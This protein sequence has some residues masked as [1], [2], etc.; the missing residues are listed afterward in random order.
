MPGIR[1]HPNYHGYRLD[2]PRFARLLDLAARRQVIVQF[3]A[4]LDDARHKWLTPSSPVD[5]QPLVQVITR[6]PSLRLVIAGGVAKIDDEAIRQ[7][8]SSNQAY[9]DFAHLAAT[10]PLP[11]LVDR[12]SPSRIVVGS[13]TPLHP[14]EP[15]RTK[16]QEATLS[17]DR[18]SAIA[19]RTA[20]ELI[21]AVPK[22]N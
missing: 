6:L 17:N 16:L 5:L 21:G 10:T 2:D 20:A 11:T 9:F 22:R 1:L 18:F 4:W 8:L 3:V 15:A 12:T 19:S 13:G 7:L 14:I